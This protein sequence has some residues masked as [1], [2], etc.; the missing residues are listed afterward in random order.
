M[1]ASLVDYPNYNDKK[2]ALNNVQHLV[3]GPFVLYDVRV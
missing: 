1:I 2:L 3:C